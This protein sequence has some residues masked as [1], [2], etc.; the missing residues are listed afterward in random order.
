VTAQPLVDHSLAGSV[1]A[2][3][4]EMARAIEMRAGSCRAPLTDMTRAVVEPRPGVAPQESVVFNMG[5]VGRTQAVGAHRLGSG[6]ASPAGTGGMPLGGVPRT[7]SFSGYPAAPQNAAGMQQHSSYAP[8][9]QTHQSQPQLQGRSLGPAP[10][11]MPQASPPGQPKGMPQQM[12]VQQ[13]SQLEMSQRL[14][15]ANELQRRLGGGQQQAMS[16]GQPAASISLNNPSLLN[17]N[18]PSLLNWAKEAASMGQFTQFDDPNGLGLN[19]LHNLPP[20]PRSAPAVEVAPGAMPGH[21]S[22][23]NNGV[24]GGS[25]HVLTVL[26]SESKWESLK[27]TSGS[28]LE[29]L[30]RDFI[31]SKGLKAA[32]ISGLVGK[33]KTMASTGQAQA[34]VDIVDLI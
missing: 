30:A 13:A 6:A 8:A 24:G 29:Q 20:P 12:G 23:R 22:G 26:T 31:S 4:S 15:R 28:H 7:G 11:G 16:P 2:P 25:Q 34:S 33:M 17:L 9:A 14:A 3:V 32:F 10:G 5:Q 21:P 27:F 19:T 18:T 1:R